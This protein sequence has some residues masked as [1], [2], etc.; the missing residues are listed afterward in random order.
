MLHRGQRFTFL[1]VVLSATLLVLASACGEDS[2]HRPSAVSLDDRIRIFEDHTATL[3]LADLT[4]PTSGVVFHP[5]P[6]PLNL[7][8][9]RSV[10]WFRLD[11]HPRDFVGES[12][13]WIVSLAPQ[14]GTA[15]AHAQREGAEG[16]DWQKLP[17]TELAKKNTAPAAFEL[18]SEFVGATTHLLLRLHTTDT[19]LFAPRLLTGIDY[20]ERQDAE[21]LRKGAYYGVVIGAI[22]YNLFLAI[23]LRAR[24]YALYVLFEATFCLSMA[25]MDRTLVIAF[26]SLL[27][28]VE[29]GLHVRFMNISAVFCVLFARDFLD[30]RGSRP[31]R[32]GAIASIVIGLLLIAIPESVAWPIRYAAA[33]ASMLPTVLFANVMT[34]V[35][36]RRGNTNALLFSIAWGTI[37][38]AA[39]YGVICK[40]GVAMPSYSIAGSLQL[41]SAIEA[42]LL[43]IA[44]ARRMNSIKRTEERVRTELAD[45]RLRLSETLQRQI[46]SLNTLVGGVAHEIGNPLNFAAGGAK[47]VVARIHQ[48]GTIAAEIAAEPAPSSAASLRTILETAS[49]SA[50]LAARGTERIESIVKNLR[51]YVG[52]GARP[53]EATDLDACIR[54]TVTLLDGH[55]QAKHVDVRLELGIDSPAIC[56]ASEMNQVIMNL[57]LNAAQA[58]STGGTIVIRSEEAAEGFRIVVADNGPGVPSNIR[59]AIFDPFFTTRAPNEGTGLGLA[60]SAE[61]ARR[62]GGNLALLPTDERT[63]GAAFALTLPRAG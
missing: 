51:H 31:I 29:Q 3:T 16:A 11:L 59:D 52:A 61:I 43:A 47:D 5:R 7:G 6:G 22:V 27:S 24:S 50:A 32:M 42:L 46:V 15:T 20:A 25:S 9:T 53:A 19:L 44:L 14:F 62:H 34:V 30:L 23:W 54:S 26:P 28:A 38:A 18:P 37:L 58:M 2:P 13:R 63:P 41:G 55:L 33:Y 21:T 49:R 35:S 57:L 36:L 40:L 60:V 1:L 39:A 10:F 56:C 8:V 17:L 45:A 12:P 48:A 4:S